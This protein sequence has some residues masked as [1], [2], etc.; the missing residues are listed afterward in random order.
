MGDIVIHGDCLVSRASE[1]HQLLLQHLNEDNDRVGVDMSTTGRCDLSFFQLICAATRSFS[2]KN[3]K[4]SLRTH[5]P[6]SL[7]KQFQQIGL[8]SACSAC[9][10]T[11][12]LLKEALAQTHKE[13]GKHHEVKTINTKNFKSTV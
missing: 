13:D 3:K 2:K 10:Y 7:K 5:L 9:R 1:L 6:D 4:L 12:C 8:T 11:D